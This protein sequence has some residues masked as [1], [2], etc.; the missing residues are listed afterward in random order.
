MKWKSSSSDFCFYILIL[1]CVVGF[2]IGIFNGVSLN[3]KEKYCTQEMSVKIVRVEKD[4]RTSGRISKIV[5]TPYFIYSSDGK[6]FNG[7][8]EY[9]VISEKY[10]VGDLIKIKINPENPKIYLVENDIT[11]YHSSYDVGKT[12]GVIALILVLFTIGKKLI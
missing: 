11:H 8:A 7:H 1:V 4:T 12:F 5:Y 10:K 6:I 2:A 9:T 3:Y